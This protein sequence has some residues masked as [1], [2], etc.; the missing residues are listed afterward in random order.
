MEETSKSGDL[1]QKHDKFMLKTYS[2]L[3]YI[4]KWKAI[5]LYLE[6]DMPCHFGTRV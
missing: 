4:K 3:Y 5:I 2:Q 6:V 1:L